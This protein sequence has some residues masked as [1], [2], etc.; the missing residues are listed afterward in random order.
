MSAVY[1]EISNR[2]DSVPYIR[3]S[4]DEVKT[5][6]GEQWLRAL[7]D[8]MENFSRYLAATDGSLDDSV[9]GF[10]EMTL[11]TIRLQ[12]NFFK[13]GKFNTL[14]DY[15]EHADVYQD[16]DLMVRRYLPGLYLAQLLWNNHYQKLRFFRD[17][18]VPGVQASRRALDVGAGPG[19]FGLTLSRQY[20]DL[21]V[22]FNDI[23]PFS[24]EMVTALSNKT[25]GISFLP[26]D[27][28]KLEVPEPFDFV[29]FSEVVEHLSDPDAGMVK[30][31]ETVNR[32]GHIFFSTAT[33]AAFYDHTVIYE[34][35]SE[36]RTMIKDHG[37]TIDFDEEVMALES[38]NGV[39]VIDYN[40]V[41]TRARK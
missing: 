19:T 1:T 28:L 29:V 39:D 3:R 8:H 32:D 30:L 25:D 11:E 24:E 4:V 7:D 38:G 41:I 6:G 33:N 35:V 27:F 21:A 16:R 12:Q 20:P 26:G 17:R 10:V 15:D 36:I 40:A 23:S 22:T 13:T 34:S 14:E 18:V 37:F 31:A 5:A 9:N 2:L